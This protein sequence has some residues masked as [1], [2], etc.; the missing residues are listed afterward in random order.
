MSRIHPADLRALVTAIVSL[1]P[2]H[3][4]HFTDPVMDADRLLTHL[5][6]S[7]PTLADL[8]PCCQHARAMGTGGNVTMLQWELKE[9]V[10]RR[11]RAET[12]L[13][14]LKA[15]PAGVWVLE[16]EHKRVMDHL[17]GIAAAKSGEPPMPESETFDGTLDE[18][19]QAVIAWGRR[20]W[21]AAAALRAEKEPGS[22]W[23]DRITKAREEARR[24]ER[25][26][27]I[28]MVMRPKGIDY[29]DEASLR[30]A[31]AEHPMEASNG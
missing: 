17:A 20:G 14:Q 12:E 15:S 18:L 1:Q 16:S 30:L 31:L 7:E 6:K 2:G 3:D 24:D 11:E 8:C 28:A 13:E 26:R 23:I 5:A 9:E 29:Q 10:A 25:E 21:D 19:D 27:I 22:G 4:S